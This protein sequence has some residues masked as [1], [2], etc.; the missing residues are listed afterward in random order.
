MA[1]P[2]RDRIDGWFAGGDVDH[3]VVDAVVA[4]A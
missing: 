1:E 3:E 4:G 2:L